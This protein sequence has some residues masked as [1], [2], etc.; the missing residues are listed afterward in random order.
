MH[1]STCLNIDAE[2]GLSRTLI[3]SIMSLRVNRIRSVSSM[4]E[5]RSIG[6]NYPP[7]RPNPRYLILVELRKRVWKKLGWEDD[8][9][10][11]D[12][13]GGKLTY[14]EVVSGGK[15]VEINVDAEGDEGQPTENP[16]GTLIADELEL[17]WAPED[18]PTL[19]SLNNML[20]ADSMNLYSWEEW[21]TLDLEFFNTIF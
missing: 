13:W 3:D 11:I 5:K 6:V 7:Q 21:G 12:P 15:D 18:I 20:V 19:E 4:V 8:R 17:A 10:G 2:E 1:I 14:D 16:V 9:K